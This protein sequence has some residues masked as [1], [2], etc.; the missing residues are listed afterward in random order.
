M[1]LNW[2]P[3]ATIG[4]LRERAR[5]IATVRAFFAARGIWEVETPVLGQGGSTD[6]HLVSLSSLARTDKGQRKLW[7]QTS[8]EFHMKRLL[9]ADSGPIFQLAKSFRDGEV[10]ARHNIE[11]TMLEWYRPGFTLAQLIEETTA[12]VEHVLPQSPGPVVYYRYRELFHRHLEVD[13]FTTSLV[14]LRSL[15]AER[16]NMSAQALAEEGRDTCLDLLMGMVIEPTL[17]QQELSVVVDYPAS[18]AA[19]ARRHQDADG[20]WV[21]SRF[22]LYLNGIELANG[23]DELTDAEEQRQ[24]FDADNAERRRLG[25][26]EVDVD[27]HLLAALEQGLPASSGVALGLD[28]LIQLALGKARLEEVLAFSTANC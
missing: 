15:A 20:E 11:F 12:L 25:L 6:V 5:L 10:G 3:T 2:Q 24:R 26:P 23:Y 8:P 9:A 4:T 17:G 18:Q 14:T 13:P 16:G 21:A 19:L 7:L 27:A 28:R 1:T 22:E